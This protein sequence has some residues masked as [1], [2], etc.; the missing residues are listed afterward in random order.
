MV[1]YLTAIL[2]SLT[3]AFP[4]IAAEKQAKQLFGAKRLG[5]AQKSA[6]HGSYAKGCIAG[7]RSFARNRPYLAGNAAFAQ[8][9]LGPP[10]NH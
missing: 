10:G 6:P 2:L 1:R 5:S 3:I 7:G 8:P 4:A 9:Q